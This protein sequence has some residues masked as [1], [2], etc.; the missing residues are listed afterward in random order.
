MYMKQEQN[1]PEGAREIDHEVIGPCLVNTFRI[2]DLEP[3]SHGTG[4]EETRS[5]H[6]VF[7]FHSAQ[8]TVL[9]WSLKSSTHFR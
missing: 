7:Q 2:T 3:K 1:N 9:K 6:L 4:E 8:L 5:G